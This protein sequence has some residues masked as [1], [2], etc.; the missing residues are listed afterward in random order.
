[1]RRLFGQRQT[2]K[3][4]NGT[5][6]FPS[7]FERYF[8]ALGKCLSIFENT[9]E[10]R[11]RD[12][13]VSRAVDAAE[14]VKAVVAERNKFDFGIVAVFAVTGHGDS[15]F[16][17]GVGSKPEIGNRN[18]FPVQVLHIFGCQFF[19]VIVAVIR[20]ASV[21]AYIR[22][23]VKFERP[24]AALYFKSGEVVQIADKNKALAEFVRRVIDEPEIFVRNG[25][26]NVR[27]VIHQIKFSVFLAADKIC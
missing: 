6:P 2:G 14:V 4:L 12:I 11:R 16:A 7:I 10:Q 3:S 25:V 13:K 1:M 21:V 17:A 15:G 5:F 9:V 20:H 27:I 19:A 26:N 18:N 24:A 22:G 8:L 23:D